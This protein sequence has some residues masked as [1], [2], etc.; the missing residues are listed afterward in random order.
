[1]RNWPKIWRRSGS[2]PLRQ[3][4]L[5]ASNRSYEPPPCAVSLKR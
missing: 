1:L 5:W 4:L 2:R 3:R